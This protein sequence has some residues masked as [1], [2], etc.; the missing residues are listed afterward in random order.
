MNFGDE[1][2]AEGTVPDCGTVPISENNPRH[3]KPRNIDPSPLYL[4]MDTKFSEG[5]YG[6]TIEVRGVGSG[7]FGEDAGVGALSE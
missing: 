1:E 4:M 6:T 7:G 2:A 5:E 3:I